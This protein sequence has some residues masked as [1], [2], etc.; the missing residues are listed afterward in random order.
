MLSKL[1]KAVNYIQWW[2]SGRFL[3][4]VRGPDPR[5]RL[6]RNTWRL[7]Q[8]LLWLG[9]T[10]A[11]ITYINV[12]AIRL[13]A[14]DK[15][16]GLRTSIPSLLV[17]LLR[18]PAAQLMER[19]TNRKRL[20]VWSLVAGRA[21]YFLIFL[22]PWLSVLPLINRIPQATILVWMVISIGIPSA[23]S[24]AGWDSFFADV[25]P[26][27]R[28]ARVVSTRSTMTNLMTLTLVPL[29]GMWLDWASF[30]FNYQVVFFIAFIGALVSTW[31]VNKIIVPDV[32]KTKKKTP[33]LSF[34]EIKRILGENKEFTTLVSGTFVYQWAIS[35]A[36]PLFM[37]YFIDHLGASDSWIGYR[38]TLASLTSIIAYRIW[39]RHIERK[40]E[41]AI[42]TLAA[43]LMGLFPLFTGL[44]TVLWPH[45]FIV[46]IPRFFGSAVM[47]SR[48]GILLRVCPA[49]RRPT[50]IA[51]YAIAVNIAAFVAP[52]VGVELAEFVGIPGVFFVAAALRV[53]AGLMYRKLPNMQQQLASA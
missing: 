53:I 27:E 40:G 18:I 52:L 44:T 2:F 43:P 48:Y 34:V 37:I 15:L 3:P 12:Y 29:F 41:R 23:L 50:Y 31:H 32:K 39:P 13:G 35:I 38:M 46:M 45:M 8:D 22:I 11:A 1:K 19:T 26:P 14:S 30:P 6:A 33:G 17:V 16:I 28:R 47:I 20:I 49:E 5:N 4:L 9:L 25:V 36:S 21:V 24:Q 51:I 42:I 7:Y 10:S